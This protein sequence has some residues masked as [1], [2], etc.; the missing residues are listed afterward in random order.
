MDKATG[1]FDYI[2]GF[3][4]ARV[5][6]LPKGMV[7][8]EVPGGK[9]VVFTC[10][11]PTLGETFKYAYNTWLPASGYQCTGGPEFELYDE[12]FSPQVPDSKMDIYIP[13]K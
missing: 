9:Y 1:E 5:E 13:I 4:V 7:R 6:D 12:D 8:W 10:T 2:A 11:L 3:E